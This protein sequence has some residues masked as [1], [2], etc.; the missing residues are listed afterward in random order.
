MA[1]DGFRHR[2]LRAFFLAGSR[3]GIRAGHANRL[4][5]ILG[6][7]NVAASP[8]DMNLPGLGLHELQGPRKGTWSVTASGN[9]R[10]TFRFVAPGVLDV[11]YED[12]H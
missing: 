9:R 6:R 11:D 5:V 4:R 10:V 8:Q 1:I 2:G 3:A 12:Y 7:L